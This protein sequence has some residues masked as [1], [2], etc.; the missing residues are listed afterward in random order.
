MLA[1]QLLDGEA[2]ALTRM[3]VEKAKEGNII[4]LRLCLDRILPSRRERPVRFA[5]PALH[6][7]GDAVAA[8]SVLADGVANGEIAASEAAELSKFVEGYVKV[9]EATDFNQRLCAL[10]DQARETRNRIVPSDQVS[11]PTQGPQQ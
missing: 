11:K 10:E 4:A 1:E 7:A 8:M 9:L 3:A 2:E 6:N 5:L